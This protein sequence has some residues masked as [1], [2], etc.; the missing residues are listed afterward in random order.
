MWIGCEWETDKRLRNGA[1][2]QR[3]TPSLD[4][5]VCTPGSGSVGN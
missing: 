4:D 3:E 1:E 2:R 5:I